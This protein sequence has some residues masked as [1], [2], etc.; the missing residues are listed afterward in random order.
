MCEVADR[1]EKIGIAK[2]IKQGIEQGIERATLRDIANMLK[3]GIPEEKL[4]EDYTEEEIAKAKK[5]RE[6]CDV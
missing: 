3:Y 1:L 5:L 4:L 2:G 6:N